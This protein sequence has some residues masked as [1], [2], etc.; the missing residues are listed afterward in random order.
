M[1]CLAVERNT[2]KFLLILN[3][4][5]IFFPLS[6]LRHGGDPAALSNGDQCT[7]VLEATP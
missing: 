4:N 3:D 1:K 5:F 6:L 2:A 7:T